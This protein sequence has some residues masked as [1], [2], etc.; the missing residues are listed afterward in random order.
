M[1]ILFKNIPIG[2]TAQE[3]AK[4]IESIFNEN[5]THKK[6]LH[7]SP[8][9]IEILEIQ[10][11]FTHP[12]KQFGLV[13]ISSPNAAQ[14]ILTELDGCVIKQCKITVKEYF[15]RSTQ[16]DPRQKKIDYAADFKEKR[17]TERRFKGKLLKVRGGKN[18][19]SEERRIQ[20]RRLEERIEQD[21][22]NQERRVKDRREHRLIH[23]RRV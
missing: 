4:L 7:I 20:D 10:D 18:R 8:S 23:S 15:S 16:N 21:R 2:T 12:I 5:G 13:T 19:R 6:D 9:T 17:T 22:R 1:D 11:N 14:K 3:L